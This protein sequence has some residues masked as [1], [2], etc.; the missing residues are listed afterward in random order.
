M[1]LMCLLRDATD[2]P[3]ASLSKS[4]RRSVELIPPSRKKPARTA[5]WL[6]GFLLASSAFPPMAALNYCYLSDPSLAAD[7]DLSRPLQR[8]LKLLYRQGKARQSKAKQ[9]KA[10]QHNAVHS[11]FPG[12][13]DSQTQRDQVFAHQDPAPSTD[14][15]ANFPI[16]PSPSPSHPRS[17][18]FLFFLFCLYRR[19]SRLSSACFRVGSISEILSSLLEQIQ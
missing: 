15:A 13:E 12:S 10:K 11:F 8:Q 5:W 9:S 19:L 1:L 6:A 3:D 18:S 7:L 17:H 2:A 16:T 14:P 4:R